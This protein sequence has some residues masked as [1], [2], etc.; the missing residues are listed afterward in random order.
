MK[1]NIQP[2]FCVVQ[3]P[4]GLSFQASL[5]FS[6]SNSEAARY[7]MALNSNYRF[8]KPGQ[9]LLV[10]DPDSYNPPHMIQLLRQSQY[11][12]NQSVSALPNE[13]AAFLHRHFGLFHYVLDQ[14][15]TLVGTASSLG[16]TYF[17][18]IKKNLSKLQKLYQREYRLNGLNRKFASP[19]FYVERQLI[20]GNLKGLLN[21]VGRLSLK[22]DQHPNLKHALKLSTKAIAHQWDKAGIGAI[23]GYSQTILQSEKMIKWMKYGGRIAIGLDFVDTTGQVIDA[24]NYGQAGKCEKVAIKEYSKFAGRTGAGAGLAYISGITADAACVALGAATG[25]LVAGICI[26]GGGLA[27][28]YIG[29]KSGE[30]AAEFVVDLFIGN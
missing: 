1:R 7:F 22:I 11:Q 9:I 8:L 19:E 23:K 25:G 24:C 14:G 18:Q 5:L 29:S 30:R 2:G 26:A 17:S 3:Q 12:V 20:M 6:H 21:K 15:G 16:D 13:S 28:G 10:A 27:G 4:R